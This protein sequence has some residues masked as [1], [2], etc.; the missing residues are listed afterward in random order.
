MG[1]VEQLLQ[2]QANGALKLCTIRRVRLL[3]FL[4]F[5]LFVCSVITRWNEGA[6]AAA[7]CYAKLFKIGYAYAYVSY[8]TDLIQTFI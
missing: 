5:Q 3:W 6:D 2:R 7:P 1:R 8:V 4:N